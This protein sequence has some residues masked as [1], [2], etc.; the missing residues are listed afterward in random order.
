MSQP[1]FIHL[2]LLCGFAVSAARAESPQ[3]TLIAANMIAPNN[4]TCPANEE[5]NECGSACEPTCRKPNPGVCTAQ[6][7]G[8][9]Q[10]KKGFIR[11]DEKV[12]VAT[13]P[14]ANLARQDN[15]GVN[16]ERKECGSACE[17]TCDQPHPVCMSL[18]LPNMCQCKPGHARDSRGVCIPMASCPAKS[19][20]AKDN[21]TCPTNEEFNECGSACEPS[22]RNPNPEFCTEQ[23][24]VG[25]Q[26]KKG[27]YRN[28]ENICVSE[29][30]DTTQHTTCDNVRCPAGTECHQV[31]LNC[32]QPPCPQPRPKCVKIASQYD[33]MSPNCTSIRC[34]NE[35]VC[36]MVLVN[37]THAQG[38][39]MEPKCLDKDIANV[40]RTTKCKENYECK[41][42]EP[43]CLN[44]PCH[45]QPQCRPENPCNSTDSHSCSGSIG[46]VIHPSKD[47]YNYTGSSPSS[48]QPPFKPIHG[49]G[50]PMRANCSNVN[51]SG[52]NVCQMVASSG[53]FN[54]RCPMTPQC[55]V[56]EL[57]NLCNAVL[58][59]DG[60][61]CKLVQPEC[62]AWPCYPQPQCVPKGIA[63]NH[64]TTMPSQDKTTRS[65]INTT[66]AIPQTLNS[67][68]GS[69]CGENEEYYLCLPRC[70]TTCR[71]VNECTSNTNGTC[72]SGCACRSGYR[73]DGKGKCVL[74]KFCYLAPGCKSNE[75]WS[76]CMTCEKKCAALNEICSVCYSGCTCREGYARNSKNL[77]TRIE[78]CD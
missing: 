43:E 68:Q 64:T 46:T 66:T 34:A 16:E 13:C 17:P 26:C 33:Q 58:C 25:C 29:C 14:A 32:F 61:V 24:V 1:I 12:C 63:H 73:R 27:F 31:P 60:Y 3:I 23:C 74:P 59:G 62:L 69:Q 30:S 37:G 76:K 72:T 50:H 71:G 40:C 55:L 54:E 2:L 67:T 5:F 51:C 65:H 75:S 10:C 18:C 28:D 9:C 22:C 41:L 6:C 36:R 21:T 4:T 20:P 44:G 7:I 11:N 70:Q 35:T 53:C 15:C 49:Q 77:C 39:I 42:V 57:A 38:L 45:P 56:K 78:N 52:D 47:H 19:N 48:P 8:K